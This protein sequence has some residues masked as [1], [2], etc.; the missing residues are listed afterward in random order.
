M[1]KSH[2]LIKLLALVSIFLTVVACGSNEGGVTNEPAT[3]NDTTQQQGDVRVEKVIEQVFV[4]SQPISSGEAGAGASASAGTEGGALQEI[5]VWAEPGTAQSMIDDPD[6]QGQYGLTLKRLFEEQNPGYTVRIE[7]Q[8][9]DNDLRQ[10]F[11]TNLM[12][13]TAPDVIVSENFFKQYVELGAIIPLDPYIADIRDDLIPGTY[14]AAEVDGQIYGISQFTG[15]FGFE[16]NCAVIE[17]AGLPCDNAPASWDELLQ[18]AKA[19]TDAGGG[20]Y[21]GF[22][23]QG[24]QADSVGAVFR[25]AV[26]LAQAGAELCQNDCTYPYFNDPNAVPVYDFIREINKYTA[27]GLTFEPD[28]GKIYT[29]LFE[30]KSA[31]QIAGSWHPKWSSEWHSVKCEDCRYSGVP[32]PPGG[33]PASI[34]VGNGVYAV[35][36]QS[37]HPDQAAA[38][39]KLMASPD[40]QSLIYSAMGRTPTTRSGLQA[41]RPQVSPAEQAY[42]DELLN[43]PDLSILPSWPSNPQAVWTVY[44]EMLAEILTS[45]KPV[46]DIMNEYQ[47]QAEIA[48]R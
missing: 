29:Q 35:T 10:A 20:E 45:D 42:I 2:N 37:K 33:A 46:V 17:K 43:N 31:Y 3:A 19:I 40:M 27:P 26:L 14:K 5:V 24:P 18:N 8:G 7:N 15:V 38:F 23:F 34:I 22:T 13:G 21:Y 1:K 25:V 30:G 47:A 48:T 41:L 4:D 9:W 32:L 28:E 16:R 44:N 39:V 11:V 6:V 36:A 12:A